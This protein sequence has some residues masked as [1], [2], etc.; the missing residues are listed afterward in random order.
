I[1]A[2]PWPVR[3]TVKGNAVVRL[4]RTTDAKTIGLMYLVTSFAF[5]IIGGAMALLMRAELARPGLQFLTNEQY[6]QL[7]TMHGTIMLLLI[8]GLGTI[9]GSVNMVT[10][11]LT[12]RAPG[13]TMFRMPIFTWNILITALLALLVFPVLAAALAAVMADRKLGAHVFDSDN[14]GA[15]LWQHL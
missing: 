4:L 15:I 8:A 3:E 11:I 10:T 1:A 6:N 7:F 12:L 9:L 13:M 5:F 2:R 14:G